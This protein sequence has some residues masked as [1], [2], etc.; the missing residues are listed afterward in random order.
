MIENR[1]IQ[2]GGF[3]VLDQRITLFS[4]WLLRNADVM[5]PAESRDLR[6]VNDGVSNPNKNLLFIIVDILHKHREF[7]CEIVQVK[8]RGV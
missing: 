7:F 3:F 1:I 8:H 2:Y 4:R 6:G 5:P